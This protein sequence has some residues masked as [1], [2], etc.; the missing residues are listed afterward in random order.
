MDGD[1]RKHINDPFYTAKKNSLFN[2]AGE[3]FFKI[4]NIEY[5]LGFPKGIFRK[6]QK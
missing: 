4:L 5:F 1:A 2:P 3:K 6:N